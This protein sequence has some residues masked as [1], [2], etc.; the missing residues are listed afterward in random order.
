MQRK[1]RH[2]T[3]IWLAAG[4]LFM[5]AC[6]SQQHQVNE[7]KRQISVVGSSSV[8]PL[9]TGLSDRYQQLHPDV[10]FFI[11]APGSST[12]IRAA[13]DGTT[14]VGMTSRELTKE[15]IET[16]VHVLPLAKDGIVLIVN[17]E[18]SVD[19]LSM[20]QVQQI[21]NGTI[22]NWKQVGGADRPILLVSRESGSGTRDAFDTLLGLMDGKRST[23][24]VKQAIFCD[25]TNSVSQNVAD[26]GN[27]I[28][29]VSL[30]SLLP[31]VK[32]I[33]VDGVHCSEETI[34]D[35][36][37]PI[38]R[39]FDLLIHKRNWENGDIP[40]DIE[41]FFAYI[42]SQ[43]GQDYIREKGFVPVGFQMNGHWQEEENRN[44]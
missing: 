3:A 34:Q 4:L 43:A 9:L 42:G 14:D 40:E 28:G 7:D 26:K 29:Y 17:D 13:I 19:A 12:G 1:K 44:G 22:T 32:P 15:E 8:E 30:G 37:Y 33:R 25:S 20:E 24:A 39:P 35:G 18:N 38:T 41:G 6:G 36:H 31:D 10:S 2:V 21:F 23:L 16:G 11:Q 27:A 5:G